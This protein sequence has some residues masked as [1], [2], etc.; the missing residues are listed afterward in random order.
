MG[1]VNT[2]IYAKEK[3]KELEDYAKSINANIYVSETSKIDTIIEILKL[4]KNNDVL[5]ISDTFRESINTS[6]CNGEQL[7]AYG[8]EKEEKQIHLI[9]EIDCLFIPKRVNGFLL[10]NE[11]NFKKNFKNVYLK[12]KV[13]MFYASAYK[14]KTYLIDTF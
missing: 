14:L 12:D 13:D 10:H 9:K 8:K 2:I 6:K 11:E 1:Y 4:N 3:T 7:I 5:L